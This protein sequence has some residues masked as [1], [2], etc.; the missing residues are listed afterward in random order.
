MRNINDY[1]STI[2]CCFAL[3]ISVSAQE[4]ILPF[5][6]EC[7]LVEER[8]EDLLGRLSVEEKISQMI[9]VS[10]PIERL[11]I[12]AYNWWNEC[13]HGVAR[14]G[15]ATS[16]PQA[17]GMA[18]TWNPKLM[19]QIASCISTEARAKYNI[20]QKNGATKRYFGLTMWTPN[21]NIFR[22]PRWGRGQESYGEDPYLTASLAVPFIKGLQGEDEQYYKVIATPKHFAVHSG[23][24]YNRHS[25]NAITNP[26]D[27]WETYLPAFKASVRE[28]KAAS[29]MSAYNRYMGESASA[30][31]LLLTKILREQ[32][33]FDG[34]VVSDCGAIYDI[35]KFHHIVETAEEASALAV[36]AGCD[37]NCGTSYKHLVKAIDLGL[38]TEAD[39]DKALRRL[40][41][42]KMKLGLFNSIDKLPFSNLGEND[43]E[44]EAHQQL[45]LQT[46]EESLVLL[47]NKNQT[48]PL[49]KNIS[50]IAVVGP[51]ANDRHVLLGNYFGVPD[52]RIT[53][54]EGI[55][56]KVSANTKVYY[57]KGVNVADNQRVFDVLSPEKL[58]GKISI[59]YFDN[60][61]FSGNPVIVK[62][63]SVVDFEWGGAAPISHLT[64]G[65]FALRCKGVINV[66]KDGEMF[67]S[68]LQT[69]GKCRLKIDSK[70]FKSEGKAI[71][72]QIETKIQLKK[73][74]DYPFELE[75]SCTNEWLASL[76]LMYHQEDLFN[77]KT[78]EEMVEKSDVVVFAGGI[79][80]RL[81]G[82]EMPVD[83]DGFHK[84][85]RTHLK[86]P[87]VQQDLLKRLKEMGK[88]VVMVVTGGSA[89]ALNWEAKELD[90]LLMAWYPG[91]AGGLAVANA[92]FGDYNPSGKLPLTFYQSVDDLPDFEDYNMA[93]RTYRYFKG[94]PLFPFGYGMSYTDFKWSKP[95]VDKKIIAANDSV[96]VSLKLSNKGR[97]DG[98]VVA[99]VYV[100]KEQLEPDQP[101][102]SLKAY[103]KIHLNKGESS[104]VSFTLKSKD[105]EQINSEGKSKLVP[106]KYWIYIGEDSSTNNKVVL[107][108]K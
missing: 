2:I 4:T 1:W 104:D 30:S 58:K 73:G 49:A 88:P 43:I 45:A 90:A 41:T 28:G 26:K 12:P 9:D 71:T 6:N 29:V 8:V 105:F 21:I 34:Y 72:D 50:S 51:M 25:F 5:R 14:A 94:K 38:V 102:R 59:E 81:E 75:Y 18:A 67:I 85:D 77:M 76:Q 31:P 79:S 57:H 93:G 44:T 56:A 108:I 15:K 20:H 95:R 103:K 97:Y 74:V 70:I 48:L 24:E 84:G 32:W 91:Q 107:E 10:P 66:D 80:A 35:Y 87:K 13:L 92:L 55:K 101:L 61:Q 3:T 68:V 62:E 99:Q 64:P 11:G 86:L 98:D 52:H 37:L 60:N 17:I 7:L 23:P 42:A 65:D 36:K 19:K 83:V 96:K 27:L 100:R 69:G 47:T 46:A 89:L 82:E 33:G 53:I 40:L 16:F 39:I 54:M 63:E 78:L 106:G 22:D